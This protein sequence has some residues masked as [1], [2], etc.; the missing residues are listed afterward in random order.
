M[1]AVMAAATSTCEKNKPKQQ[2]KI[3]K[4]L[5]KQLKPPKKLTPSSSDPITGGVGITDIGEVPKISVEM[6]V[7]G[8]I[9]V[10]FVVIAD[11]Q[12]VSGNG[13]DDAEQVVKYVES[14]EHTTNEEYV[15]VV[16]EV[17]VEV[18][19]ELRVDNSDNVEVQSEQAAIENGMTTNTKTITP[20]KS[21]HKKKCTIPTTQKKYIVP[22]NTP[23]T[24]PT[25]TRPNTP[26][27]VIEPITPLDVPSVTPTEDEPTNIASPTSPPN[28]QSTTSVP[29]ISAAEMPKPLVARNC[30]CVFSTIFVSAGYPFDTT[31]Q[32]QP[33]RTT[34]FGDS[35]DYY[36]GYGAADNNDD[37]ADEVDARILSA[38]AALRMLCANQYPEIPSEAKTQQLYEVQR[39]C[40]LGK[41]VSQLED[42]WSEKIVCELE[43]LE[44]LEGKRRRRLRR[45]VRYMAYGDCD[46][47]L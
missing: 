26:P 40:R 22:N 28:K 16:N 18:A 41:S 43:H 33:K 17:A 7:V 32:I 13:D 25:V 4:Q 3:L 39:S 27:P 35:L 6:A 8:A 12:A 23:S 37:D 2:Q 31:V 14:I 42:M 11:D 15:E 9:M 21:P 30:V 36:D 34:F 5:I 29:I 19:D 47:C 1:A 20:P 24:T 44:E 38:A 46:R 10:G 45:L